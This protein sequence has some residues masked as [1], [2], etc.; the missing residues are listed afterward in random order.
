MWRTWRLKYGWPHLCPIIYADRFGFFVV[1]PRAVKD[2][3]SRVEIDNADPD[4]IYPAITAEPKFDDWGRVN[5]RVVA[6]DYGEVIDA[7]MAK[8]KRALLR[9]HGAPL[10]HFIARA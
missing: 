6:L 7:Q 3:T 4:D 5:G 1:M 2:V 9:T 10:T 8:E